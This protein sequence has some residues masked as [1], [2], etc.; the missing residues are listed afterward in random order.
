MLDALSFPVSVL[1]I[2]QQLQLQ[3]EPA[4]TTATATTTGGGGGGGGGEA[5]ADVLN[6][7]VLGASRRA[8]QRV[9]RS[10]RYF[11]E[12]AAHFPGTTVKLWLVGP[13]IR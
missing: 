1:H 9:L 12:L 13:E 6:V 8:E 4:P 10:T 7:V 2:M 11:D 3:P 5:A